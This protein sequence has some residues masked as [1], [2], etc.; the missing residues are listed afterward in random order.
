M[1]MKFTTQELKRVNTEL[2]LILS[3]FVLAAGVNFLVASHHMVLGFYSLPTIFSAYT[4]GRRHAVL[5]AFASVFIVGLVLYRSP[6]LMQDDLASR[7]FF[8][9][10]G[11]WLEIVVWGGTLV[12][13]AYF[14]GALYERQKEQ[15]KELRQTY[16][17]VLLILQ[18]FISKDKYTQNHSYRVSIYATTIASAYRLDP[19]RIEDVR[20]AAL[21]HDIGK[22][23]ISRE[24]LYK[25]AS[26]SAEEFDE[27]RTHVVK[28]A[29]M[30][31]PVGGSLRRVLPIIL[32]HHEKFDGS[33]YNPISGEAIPLEARIIAV[34]DAYDA[35]TSDRPYR[36]AMSPFDAKEVIERGAGKE[37]DPDVV[38]A[39]L[40][41]FRKQEL[42][43]PEVMV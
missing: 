39:F 29:K 2:W 20:A 40:H 32:A 5:T 13:T 7:I 31:Q 42:E 14:M 17:G 33:G 37:F 24:I 23:E 28:G 26:L 30:L 10:P 36:K 43:V 12:I 4:F 38:G 6:H 19:E 16:N 11:N 41:A 3:L 21:L 9:I 8:F 25:A 22:L 27:M 1:N 18:Q 15:M 34:A 35:M